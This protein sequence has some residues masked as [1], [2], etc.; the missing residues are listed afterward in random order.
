MEDQDQDQDQDQGRSG[1]SAADPTAFADDA[2]NGDGATGEDVSGGD[3]GPDAD[4]TPDDVL[5]LEQV[6]DVL[7]VWEPTGEPRV[8]AALDRLTEL[9]PEDVHQHAAVFHAIHGELRSTL[10]DLDAPT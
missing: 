9:D 2:L 10:A 8:D 1:E 5:V 4:A 3:D 7:P 6:D